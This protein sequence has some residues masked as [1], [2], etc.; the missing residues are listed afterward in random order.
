MHV[1]SAIFVVE[2]FHNSPNF[3]II[4]NRV[5]IDGGSIL[6]F[7]SNIPRNPNIYTKGGF[8]TSSI[9]ISGIPSTVVE[10]EIIP[11]NP[12]GPCHDAFKYKPNS[13]ELAKWG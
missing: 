11:F 7:T 2:K 1:A 12:D 3:V 5:I 4:P 8:A 13:R 6:V 10:S 9:W